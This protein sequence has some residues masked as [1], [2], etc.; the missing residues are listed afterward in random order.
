MTLGGDDLPL[1]PWGRESLAKAKAFDDR[2]VVTV[3]APG[4]GARLR[5]RHPGAGAAERNA[6]D[7]K[8]IFLELPGPELLPVRG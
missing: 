8:L 3:D 4:H 5:E 6:A 1:Q 7:L 2:L